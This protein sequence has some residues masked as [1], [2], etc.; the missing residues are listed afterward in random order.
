MNK[1]D[2][3]TDDEKWERNETFKNE[4]Q[5]SNDF[6]SIRVNINGRIHEAFISGSAR[7]NHTLFWDMLETGQLPDEFNFGIPEFN[8]SAKPLDFV[9]HFSLTGT[10][11]VGWF[12]SKKAKGVFEKFNLGNHK[13][14]PM[15][16]TKNNEQFQYFLLAIKTQ[17]DSFIDFSKSAFYF[18]DGSRDFQSKPTHCSSLEEYHKYM[19]SREDGNMVYIAARN[20]ILNERFDKAKDILYFDLMAGREYLSQ[21]LIRAIIENKLTGITVSDRSNVHLPA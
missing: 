8:K 7:V 20:I 16:A 9:I 10:D 21:R 15:T 19:S 2:D 18:S 17:D 11:T 4:L 13:F 12:M 6:G 3:L 14:Y 5:P 1:W